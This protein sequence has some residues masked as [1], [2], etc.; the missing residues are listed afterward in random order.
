MGVITLQIVTLQKHQIDQNYSS[1]K[2]RTCKIILTPLHIS[3]EKRW[4]M[5]GQASPVFRMPHMI[6]F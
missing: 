6:L 1:V 5:R 3:Q 2:N 4:G